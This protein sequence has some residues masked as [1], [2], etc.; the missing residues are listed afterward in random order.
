[1]EDLREERADVID[2]ELIRKARVGALHI[3]D[4][5]IGQKSP[6]CAATFAL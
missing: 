6:L 4:G 2:E 1:M 5:E 3:I